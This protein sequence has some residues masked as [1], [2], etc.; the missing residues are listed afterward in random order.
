ME[1]DPAKAPHGASK[2][3]SGVFLRL[4]AWAAEKCDADQFPRLDG[5]SPAMQE[6][7]PSWLYIKNPADSPITDGSNPE[8]C[9]R[10]ASATAP[11]TRGMT[12]L[13]SNPARRLPLTGSP[14]SGSSLQDVVIEMNDGPS[15]CPAIMDS[16]PEIN[17]AGFFLCNA[18]DVD[19][20]GVKV[21]GVLLEN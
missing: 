1:A 12:A 14:R 5:T 16:C 11:S 19:L 20:R 2:P 13:P 15:G 10:C 9:R 3:L 17:R 7:D 8:G 18:A 6:R 21:R 4:R